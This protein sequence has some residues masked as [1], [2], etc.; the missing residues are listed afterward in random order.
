MNAINKKKQS[1]R[2][3]IFMKNSAKTFGISVVL[4][5]VMLACADPVAAQKPD[6]AGIVRLL[7]DR[8]SRPER[9]PAWTN[10]NLDGM[11]VRAD[12]NA[13]QPTS[14]TYDWSHI[15]ELL[16]LG[17]QHGKL[18]GL[19][20]AAGI[21]TPQWVYDSGAVEYAIQDGTG[22][23]MPIP[24][25]DAFLT[26][27]LAFV[28]ALGARYD[29]NPAL[30]YV[31]MSG[32]GQIVET[33]IAQ[34]TQDT[35]NLTNLG[36]P[37]AWKD[38]AKQISTAYANA[39]P[40]TPFF[41]T[42]A[43]P[44]PNAHGLSA[45]QNVVDWGVA[46]YPGRFG[47]MNAGLNAQSD[48]LYYPNLAVYTYRITQPVGLQMLCSAAR[49][50]VRLRG[51]LDQALMRGVQ[52]G[53]KFVE[54][55]P[56]DADDPAQQTVLAVE[57]A[58]LKLNAS[59]TPTASPTPSSTDLR[60]T[61]TDGGAIAGRNDTYTIRVTNLGPNNVTGAVVSDRF[62]NIF[63]GV[64]FTATQSGGVSGFTATGAGNISDTLT[65]PVGSFVTY[66]ATGRVSP[67]ATGILSNTATV[68]PPIEVTDP[69]L[70]NNS[71]TDTDTITVKADLKV[72]VTDRRTTVIAGRRNTYTI[73]VTNS[74]GPSDV[75]SAVVSDSFPNTFT[76]VT[77]TATESGGA[78]GFTA[79]GTGNIYDTVTL[80][81]SS[82]ITYKVKGT[83]SPSAHGTISVTGTVTAPNGVIDPNLANN[84]ATDTDT[85]Q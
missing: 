30:G 77:F 42:A 9:L 39:F 55:Y 40:T 69:N 71:A 23:S 75:S 48:T 32:M 50:P 1:A 41:I 57:G 46:T 35:I 34:T 62:P 29:G 24:W 60:V 7:S 78:S 67:S 19:S 59:P 36:G 18:I 25:D 61:V 56:V 43:K 28:N 47:I 21:Y 33:Y 72:K 17:A 51:T 76:G 68:T 31:V 63:T 8:Y 5:V 38:A 10:P 26:K 52:L 44:F 58:A 13:V 80:P 12:W 65:M 74:F 53:A 27:W 70:A 49:D 4:P 20:V 11:R 6:P 54:V 83:I 22:N 16:S 81:A 84:S 37:S 2:A 64:T 14:A 82:H 79:A 85:V 66:R 3:G 15:D 73:V 45:L